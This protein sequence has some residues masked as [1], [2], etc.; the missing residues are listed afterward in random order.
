MKSIGPNIRIKEEEKLDQLDDSKSIF[1]NVCTHYYYTIMA[2]E[3]IPHVYS[4]ISHVSMPNNIHK[5]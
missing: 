2:R 5:N 4:T 3:A 1:F